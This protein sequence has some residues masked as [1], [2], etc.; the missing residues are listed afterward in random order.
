MSGAGFVLV[1]VLLLVPKSLCDFTV[2]CS[3]NGKY[4][5]Y[6][7]NEL[8]L[9][10]SDT[11]FHIENVYYSLLNKTLIPVKEPSTFTGEDIFGQFSKYEYNYKAG[12]SSIYTS[13]Q[14]YNNLGVAKF[15]QVMYSTFINLTNHEEFHLENYCIH[16]VP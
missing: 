13:I 3:E 8:W 7:E 2:K 10:S 9:N 15:S 16:F 6:V 4:T 12:T 11:V 14:L 1:A 5:I